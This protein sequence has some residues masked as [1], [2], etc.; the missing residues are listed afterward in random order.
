MEEDYHDKWV[1][2]LRILSCIDHITDRSLF[3]ELPIVTSTP[4]LL[5]VNKAISF[6]STNPKAASSSILTYYRN[7]RTAKQ[8]NERESME[9]YKQKSGIRGFRELKISI[10]NNIRKHHNFSILAQ[11]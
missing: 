10:Q 2:I 4:S 3:G 1:S 5:S 11:K 7:E 8:S 9:S 6:W